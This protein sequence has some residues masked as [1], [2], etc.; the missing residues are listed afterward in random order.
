MPRP[1]TRQP[2]TP[3]D[4]VSPAVHPPPKLCLEK[5]PWWIKLRGLHQHSPAE[6]LRQWPEPN[7]PGVSD[8]PNVQ[9]PAEERYRICGLERG[10]LPLLRLRFYR[11]A[12]ELLRL[13]SIAARW[14]RCVART[15]QGTAPG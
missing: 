13:Q 7:L 8:A 14:N 6:P 4:R 5:H 1:A 12:P 2:S 15:K 3:Q 10:T 11:Y 9:R